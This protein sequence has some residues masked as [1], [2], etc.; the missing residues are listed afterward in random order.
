M[1]VMKFDIVHHLMDRYE[2]ITQMD[3]KYNHNI[4]DEALDTTIII[5]KYLK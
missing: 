3:L 4:F 1:G 5:G 2:R